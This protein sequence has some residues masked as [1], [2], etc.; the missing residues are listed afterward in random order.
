MKQTKSASALKT[1]L[2]SAIAMMLVAAVALGTSTYAWFVTTAAPKV[3]VMQF[4]ATS[5]TSL[6]IGLG[7]E[8]TALGQP[9][10]E[11]LAYKGVITNAD[12]SAAYD[13]MWK[14]QLMPASSLNTTTFFQTKTWDMTDL[15]ADTFEPITGLDKGVKYIP[16]WL[17]SNKD[18]NVYLKNANIVA[19][20]YTEGNII[21]PL[22]TQGILEKDTDYAISNGKW[23]LTADGAT[24]LNA[25]YAQVKKALRVSLVSDAAVAPGTSGAVNVM[26]E[27]DPTKDV[28][29]RQNTTAFG[30]AV[31]D[32]SAIT[33]IDANG[34]ITAMDA[35]T[36]APIAD[37]V[38]T[39]VAGTGTPDVVDG[40]EADGKLP[41]AV[42][43]ADT[44]KS[45]RV[46]IWL[47][48]VDF[49]CVSAIADGG[50]AVNLEFIGG[51]IPVVT[52]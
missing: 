46:F 34:K 29:G 7:T 25:F 17:R 38:I 2:F 15:K 35:Q 18:M 12:I 28:S 47:E 37:Y 42:L 52:P 22:T 4:Q 50:V 43:D 31:A 45:V 44:G 19:T 27:P 23:L 6:T 30:T 13:A 9:G 14:T 26:F 20:T 39:E 33:T 21:A 48:G 40:T 16:L 24:K 5:A 36:F 10:T 51:V 3:D 11:P 41:I 32:G 8:A 1:Q 49:D